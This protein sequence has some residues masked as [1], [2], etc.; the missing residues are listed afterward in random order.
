MN[1]LFILLRLIHILFGVFWV[2]TTLFFVLF[3]NPVV[4]AAGPAGGAVMGRLSTTRFS[5]LMAIS[6]F[7]TVAAGTIMYVIDS[8]GFQWAWIISPAGMSLTIGSLAGI[9]AFLEGLMLQKPA[10]TRLSTIQQEIQAAGGQPSQDHLTEMDALQKKMGKVSLR[11]AIM[12]VISVIGMS[13]AFN[14]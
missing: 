6:A 4:R 10:I 14:L 11:G 1:T 2:G 5:T 8:N 9:A 12:M 3:F 7:L 13:I